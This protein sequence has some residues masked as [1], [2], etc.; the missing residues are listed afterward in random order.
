MKTCAILIPSRARPDR[1]HK[2]LKSIFATAENIDNIEVIL[3]FDLDDES[4]LTRIEEFKQYPQ[5]QILIGERN[6][7]WASL[8][9]LYE[10]MAAAAKS[11]WIW[12]MNDDAFFDGN[13]WDTQLAQ[14]PTTGF[15]VQ[16]ELYQLGFSK[17]YNV[18]A[19]AFPV[20]PN[21]C[22]KQWVEIIPDPIDIKVDELLRIE[23]GWQ[24]KFLTG[25]GVIHERDTDE[26]LMQHRTM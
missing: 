10:E 4:S 12:I 13:G 20:I 17:Y 23:H 16:P 26:E 14:I 15:I 2:T 1:L 6:K 3:R 9:L 11:S 24:S 18:E 25:I 5:T 7:G 22:W 21:L 19:G 8:N